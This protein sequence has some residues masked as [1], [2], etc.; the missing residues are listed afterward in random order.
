M[1]FVHSWRQ[2][3]GYLNN[4][5]HAVCHCDSSKEKSKPGQRPRM[6]ATNARIFIMDHDLLVNLRYAKGV[7]RVYGKCRIGSGDN[8]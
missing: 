8:Y 4:R 1:L 2:S 7:I 6:F 3:P 5:A